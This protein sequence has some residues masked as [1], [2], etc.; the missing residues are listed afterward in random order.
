MVGTSG[1]HALCFDPLGRYLILPGVGLF[2][3]F[4]NERSSRWSSLPFTAA[5]CVADRSGH[6][7]VSGAP[8]D[9]TGLPV[10]EYGPRGNLIRAFT[11]PLGGSPLPALAIDLA[12]DACTLYYGAFLGDG[13]GRFNV[14]TRTPGP[15]FAAYRYTDDLRVLPQVGLIVTTDDGGIL[16]SPS[17]V[18]LR[19]FHSPTS[20][21]SDSLRWMS[22]DPGAR[23]FWM[24][25]TR[26]VI[27]FDIASGRMRSLWCVS[28]V[29]FDTTGCTA[30]LPGAAG[31]I[32]VYPG[33]L[34][35][36]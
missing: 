5:R 27:Q 23:S 35:G 25:G 4:G 28:A 12:P 29:V 15:S 9:A 3:R 7:F 32:A 6:V 30:L 20:S 33:L 13:I 31:P 17:S 36:R 24:S 1:A 16:V 11:P 19:T 10:G 8:P 22:L 21:T 26:G 18:V 2:D 34:R 14:C